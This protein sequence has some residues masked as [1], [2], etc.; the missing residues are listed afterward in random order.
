[1]KAAAVF[2]A[3]RRFAVIDHP[4]PGLVSPSDVKMRMLDVGICGTDKEIVAFDYGTPPAGSPYL[5]IGHESL[6]EVMEVGP[7]V[8]R[9]K[10]G[11]LAV[12]TVR[13]PCNDPTCI[14]CRDGRQDF[15]YSGKFTER[16]INQRHGFMTEF[17]VEEE[18]Y[19]NPVPRELRDVA[20]LVE[21]LTI[22]EK[23]VTQLWQVQQ[24]LPWA[25]AGRNSHRAVVL[26]GGPVGLLGAMKLVLEG[27]ETTVYSRTPAASDLESLVTSF[28]AKFAHAETVSLAQLAEQ[29]GNVDVVYEAVGASS[30]AFQ[31]MPFLG[32]NGV[33]IFTGVPGRKGPVSIDTDTIM[34]DHVLKNQVVFGTVNASLQSFADAIADLGTFMHRWPDAVHGLISHRFPIDQLAEPLS[35]RAGGIKNVIEVSR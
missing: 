7:A 14:A 22:A 4:E 9:V 33:F 13:R 34:R 28:G 3:E 2:P 18:R 15:C 16:G 29:V 6:G 27:F 30:L 20:V 21:P 12:P 5:I 32:T 23:G 8:T 11:D 19:L 24:R 25:V 35:G 10:P 31:M 17:V 26:G 1:M